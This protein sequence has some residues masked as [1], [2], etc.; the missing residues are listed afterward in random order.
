M[1]SMR[2]S[3]SWGIAL[4]MWVLGALL[5]WELWQIQK[6]L[7][8]PLGSYIEFTVMFIATF[9]ILALIPFKYCADKIVFN[10]E[11][12]SPAFIRS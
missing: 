9:Y 11:S 2:N 1:K 7:P 3:L 6:T 4:V 12:V 10:G 5:L 8:D